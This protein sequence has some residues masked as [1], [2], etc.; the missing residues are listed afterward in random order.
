MNNTFRNKPAF[1]SGIGSSSILIIFVTLCLVSFATLSICSAHVDL[2]LSTK[3]LERTT[4]YYEAVGKAE[5]M[6]SQLD[7]TLLN[8]YRSCESEEVYY[9]TVGRNKSFL[10]PISDLQALEINVTINYPYNN[11]DSF[12]TLE[13][14]RVIITGELEYDDSLPVL[15]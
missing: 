11:S 9:E 4:A 2:K 1:S 6:L 8:F 10:I 15:Q 3:V 7:Q 13:C 14:F 5:K 12:Y